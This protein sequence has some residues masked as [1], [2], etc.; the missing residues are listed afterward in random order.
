MAKLHAF[1][2]W[3]ATCALTRALACASFLAFV[4]TAFAAEEPPV[5]DKLPVTDAYHG[6]AVVDDYRWLEDGDD[7][8]VRAWS[9]AEN[10]Y[11]RSILDGLP[12]REAIAQRVA[13]IMSAET[14]S[15]YGV[16]HRGGKFFAM[17]HQPPK[18]QPFLVVSDSLD[19]LSSERALVDPNV[20]DKSGG[21]AIVW[22]KPSLDGK[23]VA[24]CMA[25]AG[26]EVGDVAVFDSA[27]G[28]TVG[29][30]IPRVN[31]GTA[32]GDLAWAPDGSGF[33]YTRHPRGGERP[34]EDMNFYQQVYFHKLGTP[35]AGDRYELG[36]DSPR[37]AETELKVDE[38]TRRVHPPKQKRD[39]GELAH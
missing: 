34:P 28:D 12:G 35:T 15:Y 9:Q 36:K 7:P 13:E 21:A 1:R 31:T 20:I 8:Q 39:R 18:Q 14:V 24:V 32:G 10:A 4:P 38:R 2:I 17:K 3:R 37:I 6:V 22:F 30:L 27:T 25:R 19:D 26:D 11:A 5:A 23:L 33:Y 29:E 16:A